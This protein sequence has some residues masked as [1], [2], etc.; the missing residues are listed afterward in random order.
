MDLL[1]TRGEFIS[2]P[3]SQPSSKMD[4]LFAEPFVDQLF[5]MADTT[6]GRNFV[7]SVEKRR[8]GSAWGRKRRGE[9]YKEVTNLT[10]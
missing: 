6:E 4:K 9:A 2:S 8:K 5:T 3:R 1:T 7:L 10:R